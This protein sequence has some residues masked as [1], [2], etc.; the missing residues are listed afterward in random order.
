MLNVHDD[1]SEDVNK[2]VLVVGR[3]RSCLSIVD[4]MTLR[5]TGYQS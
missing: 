4:E 5:L 3:S 2:H 1:Y